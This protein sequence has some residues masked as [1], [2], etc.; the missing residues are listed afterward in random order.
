M[1]FAERVSTGKELFSL[2]RDVAITILALLFLFSSW[3]RALVMPANGQVNVSLPG[4][5]A[6]Y[7]ATA[8][9]NVADTKTNISDVASALA[10]NPEVKNNKVVQ[11]AISKLNQSAASLQVATNSLKSAGTISPTPQ[12]AVNELNGWAFLGHVND[13]GD[14]TYDQAKQLNGADPT[15]SKTP[16][17]LRVTDQIY[18]RSDTDSSQHSTGQVVGVLQAGDLIRVEQFDQIHAIAGGH[19]VWGKITRQSR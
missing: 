7:T 19:F 3:F 9:A 13:S 14:W 12:A 10:K 4:F 17:E 5:S 15:L 11:E 2:L 6:T 1:S 8:A 16:Q 18:V